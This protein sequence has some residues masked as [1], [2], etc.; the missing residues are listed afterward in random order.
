[1]RA[2][3]TIISIVIALATFNSC[4]VIDVNPYETGP[5]TPDTPITTDDTAKKTLLIE[6]T[7]HKCTYCPDAHRK[8]KE[9]ETTFGNK[10]VVVA[11]HSGF[12]AKPGDDYPAD[13]RTPFGDHLTQIINPIGYP[14]GLVGTLLKEKV[15]A[16]TK[17]PEQVATDIV[18][19]SNLAINI[20]NKIVENR[21][22]ADIT[23]K[24]VR[25]DINLN[26]LKLYVLLVE[27]SIV[28]PQLDHGNKIENYVHSHVLRHGFTSHLG[29]EII[30]N[31]DRELPQYSE[32]F[33]VEA[34]AQWR[35]NKLTIVAFVSDELSN[36]IQANQKHIK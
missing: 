1:M 24:N 36:I 20:E 16:L 28:S 35:L 13:Y 10:I 17:W 9:L 14:K 15:S 22:E 32:K 33:T 4:D 2:L 31:K 29:K 19:P 21:I 25:P 18:K 11:V 6:F 30:L 27:D 8:I 12:Q 3:Y 23:V 7:A 5:G 26:N 34:N